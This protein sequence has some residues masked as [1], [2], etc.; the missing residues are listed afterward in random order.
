ME[1]TNIRSWQLTLCCQI[2]RA[3]G[4]CS[5]FQRRPI[6]PQDKKGDIK[7]GDLTP[8]AKVLR[9]RHHHAPCAPACQWGWHVRRGDMSLGL[10]LVITLLMAGGGWQLLGKGKAKVLSVV[11]HPSTPIYTQLRIFFKGSEVTTVSLRRVEL[12]EFASICA[13]NSLMVLVPPW[14]V[15]G[16]WM[17]N[18]RLSVFSLFNSHPGFVLVSKI[19]DFPLKRRNCLGFHCNFSGWGIPATEWQK[20]R[21]RVTTVLSPT[22]MQWLWNYPGASESTKWL[23]CSSKSF[24]FW[25]LWALRR[26][27]FSRPKEQR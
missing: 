16:Q 6:V 19:R 21:C 1:Y 23:T 22:N 4:V 14:S 17:F 5:K 11:K 8:K 3:N 9:C 26:I 7:T 10:T 24:T 18:T 27:C 25:Q 12:F 20:C 13:W 15:S 2:I